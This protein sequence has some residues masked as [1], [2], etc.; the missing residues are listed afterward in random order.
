MNRT[1]NLNQLV[2]LATIACLVQ[3]GVFAQ[4]VLAE[5]E[6]SEFTS[7]NRQRT[8]VIEDL[9]GDLLPELVIGTP[10]AGDPFGESEYG[11]VEVIGSLT[12]TAIRTHH[13]TDLTGGVGYNVH[14]LPDLD[15][16]GLP[17]ILT[18][19]QYTCDAVLIWSSP[20]P[21][22][23]ISAPTECDFV[24]IGYRFGRTV[25]PIADEDGDGRM[26]LMIGAPGAWNFQSGPPDRG[27]AS[28]VSSATGLELRRVQGVGGEELGHA[29][30]N[31]GDHNG[32]GRDDVWVGA[33]GHQGGAGAVL[34]LDGLTGLRLS[35]HLG[36]AG[37]SYGSHVVTVPDQN[38]DGVTEYVTTAPLAA[39]RDGLLG[40][41]YLIDGLSGRVMMTMQGPSADVQF[42]KALAYVGDTDGDGRDE[43]AF[44][45]PEALIPGLLGPGYLLH[46]SLDAP[47]PIRMLT[48]ES[49]GDS[50]RGG[51][52]LTGGLDWDGD[53]LSDVAV[54]SFDT[55]AGA[56]VVKIV[57]QC[58][59][60]TKP[61]CD[62]MAN[63]TGQ[64][65]E[66]T[67]CAVIDYDRGLHFGLS[68]LP[69]QAFTV[70]YMA[71]GELAGPVQPIGTCLGT[72]AFA[73]LLDST[74]PVFNAH[75]DGTAHV[76][77][78]LSKHARFPSSSWLAGTTWAFQANY[79]DIG[80]DGVPVLAWSDAIELTLP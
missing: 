19:G 40:Q 78:S 42:G 60:H 52:S 3:T 16:D 2:A 49:T 25:L 47:Q 68:G 69:S 12:G 17:E 44:S 64:I 8:A 18:T 33:P 66:L 74:G 29:L 70:L 35:T 58:F 11:M 28:I 80:L 37:G 41:G 75:A 54:T 1:K 45:A 76:R 9:D 21:P 71:P 20:G 39:G 38:G 50:Y 57:S 13:G 32:D 7:F 63:S 72:Q 77:M 27:M 48:G 56:H 34:L 5:W 22:L 23:V 24:F 59:G 43:V 26:E 61:V 36:P 46:F 10:V 4:E 6:S 31:A 67:T 15:G 51:L 79:G 73:V 55:A 65:A 30:A 53:G 14:A 62:G